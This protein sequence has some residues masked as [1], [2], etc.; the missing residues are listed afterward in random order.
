MRNL[1][2]K[3]V[4][5]NGQE[6]ILT[7]TSMFGFALVSLEDGSRFKDE[8]SIKNMTRLTEAEF[9]K[10]CGNPDDW[11]IKSDKVKSKVPAF[12]LDIA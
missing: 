9:R 1:E 6:Y 8:I 2:E 5:R 4:Y 12:S 7:R 3:Y 10:I 11:R